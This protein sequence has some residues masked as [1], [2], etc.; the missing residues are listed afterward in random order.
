MQFSERPKIL[1]SRENFAL[2]LNRN[3]MVNDSS[4]RKVPPSQKTP[5]IVNWPLKMMDVTELEILPH[6][7]LLNFRDTNLLKHQSGILCSKTDKQIFI[8]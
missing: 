6:A 5:L 2:Q 1:S 8:H 4:L 3:L 7:F